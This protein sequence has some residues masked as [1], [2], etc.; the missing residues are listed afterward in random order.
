MKSVEISCSEDYAEEV[1]NFQGMYKGLHTT[2]L[3]ASL[4]LVSTEGI[5]IDK[6]HEGQGKQWI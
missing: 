6:I 2:N 5:H 3:L 4:F 1:K